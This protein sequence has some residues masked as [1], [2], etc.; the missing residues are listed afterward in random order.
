MA[1]E[2]IKY[3]E[4]SVAIAGAAVQWL[5]DNL[6]LIE[7][8]EQIESYALEEKTTVEYICSRF[9]RFVFTALG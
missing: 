5:R 4:R 7:R 6:N 3:L 2:I 8:S 9:L 1:K